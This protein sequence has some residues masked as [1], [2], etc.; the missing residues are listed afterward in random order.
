[1]AGVIT[2]LKNTRSAKANA[3]ARILNQA[4]KVFIHLSLRMCVNH[5]VL[6]GKLTAAVRR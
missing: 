4:S 1:M 2:N 6:I 3:I 5:V